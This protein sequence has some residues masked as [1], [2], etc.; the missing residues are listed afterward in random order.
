MPKVN[1]EYFVEKRNQILDAAFSVCN[2]KPAYDVTM[3]DIV[4][5]I[6]LARV[7]FT[8]ILTI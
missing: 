3:S 4:A 5:E 1:E 2:R 8:S 7:G 6:A